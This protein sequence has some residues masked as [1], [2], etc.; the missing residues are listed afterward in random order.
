MIAFSLIATN[1]LA[2]G[3]NVTDPQTNLI[4]NFDNVTQ[5]EATSDL[6]Q[7]QGLATSTQK[8]VKD[9]KG[10][11]V[12][13]A[14][15]GATAGA[16]IGAISGESGSDAAKIGAAV[17]L[18]NGRLKGNTSQANQEQSNINAY[19]T[20]LRNCMIEKHYVSLN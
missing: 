11:G 9:S 2:S 17:G 10:S 15:R 19:K 12:S 4:F 7:C 8:K 3:G 18:L 16:A 13:G 14:A 6:H 20:V 5:T 1:T